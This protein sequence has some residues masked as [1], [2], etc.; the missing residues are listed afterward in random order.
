MRAPSWGLPVPPVLMCGG[1]EGADRGSESCWEL[2]LTVVLCC[3]GAGGH[4]GGVLVQQCV[5][6]ALEFAVC[7]IETKDGPIALLPTEVIGGRLPWSRNSVVFFRSLIPHVSPSTAPSSRHPVLLNP[8][9]HVLLPPAFPIPSDSYSSL[10]PSPSTPFFHP[11]PSSFP[12]VHPIPSPALPSPELLV[13][14]FE[15][16]S[17]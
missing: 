16:H 7:V 10:V 13:P 8:I 15:E 9:L 3:W 17:R 6:D 11:L 5:E 1:V 14:V 12:H 2:C 4:S